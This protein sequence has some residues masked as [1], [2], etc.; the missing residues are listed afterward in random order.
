MPSPGQNVHTEPRGTLSDREGYWGPPS[1]IKP[2]KNAEVR[3]TI[4]P[5]RGKHYLRVESPSTTLDRMPSVLNTARF[6]NNAVS[7]SYDKNG[8]FAVRNHTPS[9]YDESYLESAEMFNSEHF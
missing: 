5:N 7:D 3:I 6:G 9:H 2:N 4:S 8:Q 1:D